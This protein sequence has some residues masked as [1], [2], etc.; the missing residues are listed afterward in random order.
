MHPLVILAQIFCSTRRLVEIFYQTSSSRK[1]ATYQASFRR[2]KYLLDV[3]QQKNSS[4]RRLVEFLLN[5]QQ[6]FYQTSSRPDDL[7]HYHYIR[8]LILASKYFLKK[9]LCFNQVINSKVF[10]VVDIP[11]FNAINVRHAA[12][13]IQFWHFSNR[14]SNFCISKIFL[15]IYKSCLPD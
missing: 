10:P 15:E 14:T 7:G 13:V 5:A 9:C 2:S 1:I 8:K 6:N 12:Y 3:Q 4:T 11:S